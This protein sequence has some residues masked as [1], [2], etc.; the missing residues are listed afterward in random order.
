F[1]IQSP[2]AIVTLVRNGDGY[3][4][5]PAPDRYACLFGK[6]REQELTA[7]S[8]L[9]A[10]RTTLATEPASAGWHDLLI[11]VSR[12]AD[13]AAFTKLIDL[14]PWKQPGS[15]ISR[16]WPVA[17]DRGTLERR[18]RAF[19]A[20]NVPDERLMYFS[21]SK[22]GRT[23]TTRIPGMERLIDLNAGAAHEP[24][25]RFGVRSFDRQ[26]TFMDPRLAKTESPSL[27]ASL[28]DE[29]VFLTTM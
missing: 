2:V 10:G 21:P 14:F 1:D 19:V 6:T 18:W 20:T 8:D 11:P 9:V 27:W 29:Q 3:R 5:T 13:S 28:S 4:T 16:T 17:P 15:M 26:W 25:V 12:G 24:I 23:I 22:T 7:L